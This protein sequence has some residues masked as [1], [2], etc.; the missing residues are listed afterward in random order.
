MD[1]E[2]T[3]N[4][5]ATKVFE[6]HVD[7][8]GRVFGFDEEEQSDNDVGGVVGDGSFDAN[9][10]HLDSNRLCLCNSVLLPCNTFLPNSCVLYRMP[11]M[12]ASPPLD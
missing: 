8:F 4:D 12:A 6:V 11:H 7:G 2:G 9:D 1:A 10:A 3:D 5:G